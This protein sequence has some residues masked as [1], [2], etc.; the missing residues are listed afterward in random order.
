M[1]K[2]SRMDKHEINYDIYDITIRE[3][4]DRIKRAINYLNSISDEDIESDYHLIRIMLLD[5]LEGED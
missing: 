5:I 1:I 2:K 4:K 3:Y